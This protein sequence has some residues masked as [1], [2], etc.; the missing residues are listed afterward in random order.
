ML[1]VKKVQKYPEL[2]ERYTTFRPALRPRRDTVE[3]RAIWDL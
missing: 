1:R 2:T 3:L